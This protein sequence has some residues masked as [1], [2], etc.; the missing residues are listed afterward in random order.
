MSKISFVYFD[1][2]GVVVQDSSGNNKRHEMFEFIGVPQAR[3]KEFETYFDQIEIE[4]TR[5]VDID[6]FIEDLRS[7]FNVTIPANFSFLQYVADFVEPNPSLWPVIKQAQSHCPIGLLTDMYPHL[8][9]E[10]KKRGLLP[11]INW[12][13]IVDSSIEKFQKPDK[14]LYRIAET[15][16]R[17]APTEILFIDNLQ[18]NLDP[19]SERSWQTF[20]Y[21]PKNPE[22]SSQELSKF[23]NQNLISQYKK[24]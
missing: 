12:D 7:K 11:Q 9:D 22:K 17:V 13:V 19:A 15:K 2:G 20:L 21:D 1:V 4:S 6:S 10:I 8:L 3:E 14:E 5:G 18:V 16:A 23:L 24:I